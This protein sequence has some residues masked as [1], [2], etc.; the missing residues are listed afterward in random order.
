[1]Y[2]SA[3]FDDVSVWG[4]ALNNRKALHI[5][6]MVTLYSFKNGQVNSVISQ[7]G[8]VQMSNFT[9]PKPNN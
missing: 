8:P 6:K 2:I 3:W 7:L 4:Q 1:M 5:F 9:C